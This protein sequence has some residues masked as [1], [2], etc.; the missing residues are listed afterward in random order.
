[1]P[2]LIERLRTHLADRYRLED[3]VGEGGMAFVYQAHD[4]RHERRV[5]IKVLRPELTAVLGSERFLQEIRVTAHLQHPHVLALYDSGAAEGL[6]YYVMPFVSGESLRAR[7]ERERQLPVE[8]VVTM[9]RGIASA[10]DFA[11][12]QGV[13]HRD[14]KPENILIQEGQP[15]VADFGIALAVRAAAGD[16]LTQTGLSLGTPHYMS[17]EQIGGG[18]AVDGR[19]DQYALACVGYEALAGRP[20]HDGPTAQAIVSA[21]LTAEPKALTE[22]RKSVPDNVAFAIHKGLAKVPADRYPTLAQFSTALTAQ[23]SGPIVSAGARRG[24]VTS[25]IGWGLAA[26]FAV[27]AAVLAFREP[28]ASAGAMASTRYF[29]LLLPENAPVALT[30]PGP[31]GIWQTAIAI[32]PSGDM[33]AYVTPFGETTRL[34]I[35]RLDRDSAT[36]LPGT[37]G[38]FHPFFSRD[39]AWIGYFSGNQLRKVQV[40]GSGAITLGQVARPVGAVWADS[41]RIL[42]FE[43]D[44]FSMRWVAADG[45]GK[46]SSIALSTQFGTPDIL[47]GGKWVAGQLSSGQLALVSVADGSQLVVTRRGV[48]PPDS[49][50]LAD[51]LFG[52]S[53]KWVETGHLVFTTGDGTLE[54][55]PFDPSGPRTLGV[56]VPLRSGVRIEE[57]FSCSEHAIS[58]EGTLVFVPGGNQNFGRLAMLD[59]NG[60]LDTLPFPRS[61][62]RQLRMSRDGK[63]LAVQNQLEL[64]GWEVVILD[65]VTG[66]RRKIQVEGDYRAFPADW[67][68][69]PDK[70]L[71]GLWDPVRFLNHGAR[72]YSFTQGPGERLPLDGISYISI[73]PKDGG[74]VY[75]DWRTGELYVQPFRPDTV[76]R[77]KF[78]GRGFSASFSPDGN[79][80]AWGDLDGGVSASPV[81]PAGSTAHVVDR[82]QQPLWSPEGDRIIYRD[83]RRVYEVPVSTTGGFRTTGPPRLIAEG[84]FVRGFAWNQGMAPDGRLAVLVAL[85][86]RS[87]RD[88]KV[89][90]GL[91]AELLR[92]APL[93]P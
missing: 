24:R 22:L 85:P 73:S 11:H 77:I 56:P 21:T 50:G 40:N 64:G 33:L 79:W 16:R 47:P 48:L 8:D 90:T 29:N 51:L 9:L 15:L 46:D 65:L 13:I 25:L 91:H 87:R 55:L 43:Q 28:A 80:I 67:A 31:G 81:P 2:L 63:G 17:P 60:A 57:G 19:A 6:L 12:R 93:S 61:A 70:I 58:R 74:L 84:P 23:H 89:I 68:A 10:L 92:L 20:P 42:L 88:L 59:R 71:I 72:M 75:S 69:D 26:L 36:V 66:Q 35:R 49:V 37:D 38:A 4:I 30:G 83:G 45:S 52:A 34:V 82:G 41:S 1:M 32:A 54:A 86:E 78:P 53:P 62:Y 18:M 44:G 7:L 14:I 3:Q 39:G 76:G 27:V 5:A